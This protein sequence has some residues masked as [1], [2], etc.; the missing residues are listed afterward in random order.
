MLF[1]QA[2]RTQRMPVPNVVVRPLRYGRESQTQ[3]VTAMSATPGGSFATLLLVI[4]LAAIPL[5]AIFGIPEFAH[6]TASED[7]SALGIVRRPSEDRRPDQNTATEYQDRAADLFAPQEHDRGQSAIAAPSSGSQFRIL[8]SSGPE[9]AEPDDSVR[10]AS[11]HAQRPSPRP[12]PTSTRQPAAAQDLAGQLVGATASGLT[13][14]DASRRLEEIGIT[15]YR[16][17]RGHQVDQFLFVCRF[18]PGSDP[19]VVQRF[20]AESSQPLAAVEDVLTQVESWLQYRYVES[21]RWV[22]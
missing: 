12:T 3:D 21:R 5:M 16:L 7:S 1:P 17:E 20:E 6:V 19:R 22:R 13:W 18:S 8:A 10:F 14:R 4:P 11:A 2:C 15:D 9:P